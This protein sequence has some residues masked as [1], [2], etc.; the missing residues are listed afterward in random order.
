MLFTEGI[1]N[2]IQSPDTDV[3]IL[4][5]RHYHQLCKTHIASQVWET[6]SDKSH[7][8]QIGLVLCALPGFS[9]F[10]GSDYTYRFAEKGKLTCW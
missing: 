4:S 7:L 5:L 8:G 10:T 6:E 3:F 1:Q 9:A 2:Y